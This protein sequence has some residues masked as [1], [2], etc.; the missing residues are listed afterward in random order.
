MHTYSLGNSLGNYFHEAACALEANIS[1]VYPL[2]VWDNPHLPLEYKHG[3]NKGG[4]S[5]KDKHDIT[6]FARLPAVLSNQDITH[7]SHRFYVAYAH[8]DRGDKVSLRCQRP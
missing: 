6:F 1:I 8:A 3:K 7:P 2:K 5:P 4:Y